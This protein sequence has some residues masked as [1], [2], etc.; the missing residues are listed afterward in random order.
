MGSSD[1]EKEV[2]DV[3]IGNHI[4]FPFAAELSSLSNA[5]LVAV[6]FQVIQGEALGT[7]ESAFKIGVDDPSC[8]G[9][10]GSDRNGPGPDF[11]L[12]GREITLEAQQ[13]V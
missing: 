5:F 13:V 11:L 3:A 6:K 4:G 7:D 12:A 8:L 9:S 10:G 2:D 1:I